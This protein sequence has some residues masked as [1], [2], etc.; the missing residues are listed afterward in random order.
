MTKE[1]YIKER[2][3]LENKNNI[4]LRKLGSKFAIENNSVNIGDIINDHMSTIKVDKIQVINAISNPLLVYT[5]IKLKKNLNP[6]KSGEK[7]SIY[8]CNLKRINNKEYMG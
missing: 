4:S 5:G 2:A 6:F 1:E 8:Q 3:I 7:T